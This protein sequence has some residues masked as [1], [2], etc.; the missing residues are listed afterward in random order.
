VLLS[1]VERMKEAKVALIFAKMDPATAQQLT[2]QLAT[3]KQIPAAMR[4]DG[5]R[6]AGGAA[7]AASP[8]QAAPAP[9]NARPG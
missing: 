7:P 6:P 9:G 5:S 4:T 2:V 3:R 8:A 1:V